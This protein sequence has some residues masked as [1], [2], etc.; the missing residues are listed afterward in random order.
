MCLIFS[1]GFY[2]ATYIQCNK[3]WTIIVML[4]WLD[5]KNEGKDLSGAEIT[6]YNLKHLVDA[7]EGETDPRSVL[8]RERGKARNMLHGSAHFPNLS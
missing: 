7:P 6:S 4:A 2:K 5:R 1:C 8:A 3:T